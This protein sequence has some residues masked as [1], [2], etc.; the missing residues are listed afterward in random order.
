MQSQTPTTSLPRRVLHNMLINEIN[1]ENFPVDKLS[2]LSKYYAVINKISVEKYEEYQL[3]V[4]QLVGGNKGVGKFMDIDQNVLINAVYFMESTADKGLEILDGLIHIFL[5]V[6]TKYDHSRQKLRE[7][8]GIEWFSLV[9]QQIFS[10]TNNASLYDLLGAELS[11]PR[12]F[13]SSECVIVRKSQENAQ[14]ELPPKCSGPCVESHPIPVNPMEEH[15]KEVFASEKYDAIVANAVSPTFVG[16]ARKVA[17]RELK[18]ATVFK[19]AKYIIGMY[20]L[21]GSLDFAKECLEKDESYLINQHIGVLLFALVYQNFKQP[22]IHFSEPAR[23]IIR[24]INPGEISALDIEMIE[25]FDRIL[26]VKTIERMTRVLSFKPI[27]PKEEKEWI[28]EWKKANSDSNKK[29]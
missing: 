27:Q 3:L 19:K 24:N 20:L 13:D 17:T 14:D 22:S 26:P 23:H 28:D 7:Y 10:V 1:S 15:V 18:T 29:I 9:T 12:Q 8:M 21:D 6:A 16:V 25:H 4:E 2:N 5:F 11:R